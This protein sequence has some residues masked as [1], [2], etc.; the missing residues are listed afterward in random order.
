MSV[1]RPGLFAGK[2]AL[3][4]GG[5]T[6]I[7]KAITKELLSLGASVTIASRNT[8]QL[9]KAAEELNGGDKLS[10]M[11]CNIRKEEDAK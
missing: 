2:H 3:V 10:V 4:T 1:F 7:G 8:E 5:G 11:T 9:E 6:G